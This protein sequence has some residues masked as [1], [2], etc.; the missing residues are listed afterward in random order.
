MP[1]RPSLDLLDHVHELNRLFLAFLRS[2]ARERRDCLGLPPR[3]ERALLQASPEQLE[4]LAQFPHAL[5]RLSLDGQP[6]GRTIDPLRS[7]TDGAHYSL[8]LM[9]LQSARALSRQS[10]YQARL[11]MGLSSRAMQRLRGMPLDHLPALARTADLVLCAF[12]ERDWLWTE[13]LRETR[14]EARQQ[15]ALIALQPWLE[16]EWP[17]RRFAQLSP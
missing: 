8:S 12:P 17:R 10:T 16:Q 7:G 11:L 5:F 15:L 1:P 4:M 14:P 6:A 2:A 13:L 3:A 9:I